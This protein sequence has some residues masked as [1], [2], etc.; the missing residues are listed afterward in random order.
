MLPVHLPSFSWFPR[1]SALLA[2]FVCLVLPG[3]VRAAEA[4]ADPSAPLVW[5][6]GKKVLLAGGGSSHDFNRWFNQADGAI[7]REAGYSVNYTES[8]DVVARE[9]PKVD[10]LVLSANRG[11][12][13][14]P[15]FRKALVEFADAGHGM[16]LFHPG[17]WYNWK[18]TEYNRD[19]V[20]GG[21]RGHDPL[22]PF[23]VTALKEHPVTKGLPAS[24]NVTDELYYFKPATNGAAIEVLAQTSVAKGTKQAHPSVWIVKHPKARIVGIALGHDGKVHDLPEF[25]T[26]LR[27]A[28]DWASGGSGDANI[29]KIVLDKLCADPM[30]LAVAPDGRVIYIERVGTMKIWKPDTKSTVVAATLGVN[31]N[32]SGSKNATWEDGLAGVTLDPAF[33]KNHWLY[34]FYSPTNAPENRVSRFVLDGDHLALDSEQV[35]LR[36][37]TDRAVCCHTAGSLAFDG[38]GNLFISTGDNTNP[39]ESDGYAPIDYRPGRSGFDAA[40]SAANTADL[41]GKILRVHPEPAGGY[42]VPKGNLFPPGTP[43]TRAEIYVMGCRNPFRINVDQAT[44]VLY[45]GD[46][47]PDSQNT[48]PNRG[49]AGYDAFNKTTRPANFGWPFVRGNNQAYRPYDFAAKTAGPAFDPQAPENLSPNNTGLRLLPPVQPSWIWYP[50][51]PSAR[52]PALGSG[53]R[54]ACAGP[55]YHFNAALASARK[56]PKEFD[57]TFF[58]YDWARNWIRAVK[59][60]YEGNMVSMRPFASHLQF[61]KPIEMELGPDGCL[62]AIEFGTAWEHNTDSQVI[63]LEWSAEPAG[64]AAAV[65]RL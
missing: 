14:T 3:S 21:A 10:L 20:G 40:R 8:P 56:L 33:A 30:E 32:P 18:W 16:I 41:R 58:A 37:S 2:A 53:G 62:Y 35:V 24:F 50:Y 7:L 52:F 39:F 51:A 25:K 43:K 1:A 47:G 19:F 54:A 4:P 38:E 34:L 27:N 9:L 57:N 60:D 44:G 63:R 13:D 11:G 15:D 48:D 65:A 55:I 42:T 26:L 17:V 49:P 6:A 22:G 12:F 5:G 46:V 23:E 29:R 31:C 36:I 59:L 45:W 61:K 28:A 64:T